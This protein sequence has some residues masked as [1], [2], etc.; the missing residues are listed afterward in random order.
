[1]NETEFDLRSIFGLLRRQFRLIVITII[2]V[3][4]L[5]GIAVFSLTPV[6]TAS[7]L[8]LVDPSNK[9]LLD[10]E[11]QG[12]SASAD[13][14]RIDSEVELV[15]SDNV[16]LK[17]IESQN[18]TADE[19]FGVSLGTWARLMSFLRLGAPQLPSGE[20]ALNQS[21]GRL[22]N[23]VTVQRRALTYLISVQVRSED[24]AKSALLA[25]A[26]TQAYISDQLA[27]KV[28]SMLASRDILLARI[29]QARS[30]V[31]SSET[32]F[33]N[34]IADNIARITADTGRTDFAD[35]QNQIKQLE[36][37]RSASN[38][39]ADRLQQAL[40]DS[41]LDTLVANLQGEAADELKRQR[42]ALTN[43]LQ[44]ATTNSPAAINL[45]NELDTLEDQLRKDAQT[46]MTTIRS[47]VQATQTQEDN[48]RQTMR[49]QVLASS[50][51]PDVLTRLYELQQSSE[52]ARG[53]YQTLLARAQDLEA[54][55]DLQL[56]DSRIVSPALTPLSPSF[57]NKALV[58][59]MAALAALGL[60]VAL[61]FLYENLIGG[62][63]TEDQV[64]SVLRTTVATSIPREKARSG[65]ES[66]ANMMVSSPLS[67]FAELIRRARAT[68]EQSF[69]R[70]AK[71]GA[72][73]SKVIMVTSTAPNEGKT[74][75]ALALA[76]SYALSGHRTLLIDCDLRKPSLHRHIGV[77]PSNGLLEFLSNENE[78][79]LTLSTTMSKDEI[80][81]VTIIVGARRSDLATDQLLTGVSFGNLISAARK[82]FDIV[83]L[84]TPPI[85]PVVDGLYIAPFAD[86]I[87]FVA[88]WASTSQRDA[89]KSVQS[90]AA[91]KLPETEIIAVLNQQDES[92]SSYERKYG[93]YYTNS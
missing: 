86:A 44:S 82:S 11:A 50:L 84:D 18:L 63:T 41:D 20:D 35:M 30:A 67:V 52:L 10:P 53:Q 46:Q 73:A 93:N 74:T 22:R 64:Q 88:R 48:L 17:V 89:K 12:A 31:S 65:K 2:A 25:N 68:I 62:F 40:N 92:Q 32:S 39:T 42:D 3:V 24:R 76:R 55:A 29:N 23:A 79:A 38:T 57:P 70:N 7:A 5:A 59:A 47:A 69:R 71:E 8:V 27:S 36:E 45:R 43:S 83:V 49:T 21:L 16:L 33:D 91:A 19:Q 77:E 6:Y 80:T 72:V 81:S 78:T 58:L 60:G 90:L 4:A 75:L 51:S 85:G 15:R 54:Q 56:A 87:M 28:N 9:N 26:V 14:A 34:F 61:A 1:M 66:L 37:A 13:S